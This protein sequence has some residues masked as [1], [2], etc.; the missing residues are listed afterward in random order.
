MLGAI[1]GD[2]VGSIYEFDNIRRKDFLLFS[3]KCFFTD[4]SAMTMAVALALVKTKK[5]GFKNLENEAIK[6]MQKFGKIYPE[7]SYGSSFRKWLKTK[8]PPPTDSYGNGAAMRV[9]AVAYFAKSLEE[10][11]KLSHQVTVV[12]HGH[13]EGLKGAEATAIAVWLALNGKTK[14]EIKNYIEENYYKLDFDYETLKDKYY[15]NETCQNTVPQALYCFL[16]SS[17]FEDCLRASVSIGGD[18]DTLCAISCAVAEA[19]Y[20]IPQDIQGRVKTYLDKR[21]LKGYEKFLKAIR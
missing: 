13:P 11:K 8:N 6:M 17:D 1:V 15:F 16:I 3:N 2:V 5:S 4:D 12:S 7:L 21:M 18:T 14:E 20:G 9:S 19:F 10:V